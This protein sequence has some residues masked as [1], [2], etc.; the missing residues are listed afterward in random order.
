MLFLE[1]KTRSLL[2]SELQPDGGMHPP[3]LKDRGQ[4]R[5]CLM[6]WTNIRTHKDSE[7]FGSSECNTLLHCELYC[8]ELEK[9]WIWMEM[10]LGSSSEDSHGWARESLFLVVAYVSSLL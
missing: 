3:N 9:A 1:I 10:S 8:W 6:R 7:W 4:P 5:I 2:E